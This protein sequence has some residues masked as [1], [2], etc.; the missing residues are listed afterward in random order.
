MLLLC[1]KE[2]VRAKA[3]FWRSL[4]CVVDFCFDIF[5]SQSSLGKSLINCVRNFYNL[6]YAYWVYFAKI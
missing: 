3:K 5:L 6:D 4:W 1:E 2:G